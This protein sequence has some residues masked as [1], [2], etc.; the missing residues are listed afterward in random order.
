MRRIAEKQAALFWSNETLASRTKAMSS[1][2]VS[3]LTF[4]RTLK[5]DLWKKI[6]KKDETA[7]RRNAISG[8]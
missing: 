1:T 3:A 4:E 8:R 5:S 7:S 6:G 2:T